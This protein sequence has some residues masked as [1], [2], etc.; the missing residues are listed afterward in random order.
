MHKANFGAIT[1]SKQGLGLPS[2]FDTEIDQG[3]KRVMDVTY[4]LQNPKMISGTD[5]S[6]RSINKI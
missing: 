3:L 4:G 6:P 5:Q 2:C 1:G